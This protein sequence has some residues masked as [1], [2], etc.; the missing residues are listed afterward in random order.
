[1][2]DYKDMLLDAMKQG[3]SLEDVMKG[4]STAANAIEKERAAASKYD[5]YNKHAWESFGEADTMLDKL[6]YVDKIKPEDMAIVMTHFVCQNVPGYAAAM[7]KVDI[8][9]IKTYTDLMN[10]QVAA[11]KVIADNQD[12]SDEEK[13]A[14]I[15]SHLLGKL[16]DPIIKERGA[17][18]GDSSLF[19]IAF[20]KVD[21]QKITSFLKKF[22]F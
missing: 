7:A 12:K 3:V 5:K 20:P 19:N 22:D 4:I 21:E 6:A 1:M 17:K 18:P 14:A 11:A 2:S 9:L 15:I 8:D 13:D 10:N 16:F